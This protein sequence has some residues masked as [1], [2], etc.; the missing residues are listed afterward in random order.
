[1][2]MIKSIPNEHWVRLRHVSEKSI[3]EIGFKD[4]LFGTR[5]GIGKVGHY[6]YVTDICAGSKIE[7]QYLIYFYVLN[8]MEK[9][10]EDISEN[11]LI[12]HF[13][14]YKIRPVVQDLEYMEKLKYLASK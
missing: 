12:N 6:C 8:I 10:P 13:P 5:I 11:D 7:D 2:K 1:M 3:W 14:R 4:V 9:L